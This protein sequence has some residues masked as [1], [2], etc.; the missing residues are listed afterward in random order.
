MDL[1]GVTIYVCQSVCVFVCLRKY[2][3]SN[4]RIFMKFDM[5]TIS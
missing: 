3:A 2:V 5:D 1:D 4:R